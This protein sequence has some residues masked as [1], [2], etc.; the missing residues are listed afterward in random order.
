MSQRQEHRCWAF[1]SDILKFARATQMEPWLI[2][3]ASLIG[4]MKHAADHW[5]ERRAADLSAL[6]DTIGWL[7]ASKDSDGAIKAQTRCATV[8]T[9]R[10]AANLSG[11]GT[12]MM[13][14]RTPA[15]GVF[16]P[17]SVTPSQAKPRTKAAA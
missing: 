8:L 3:Q 16:A 4:V 2:V 5:Y 6:Q 15:A 10:L 9:Q 1:H 17:S 11:L 7:A 13:A 14:L 12:D